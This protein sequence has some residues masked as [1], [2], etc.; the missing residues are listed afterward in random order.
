MRKEKEVDGWVVCSPV[1]DAWV[2]I[3]KKKEEKEVEKLPPRKQP[4]ATK[5]AIRCAAVGA[6]V[7]RAIAELSGAR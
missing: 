3:D 5:R 2:F 6:R 1:E 7:A 4:P